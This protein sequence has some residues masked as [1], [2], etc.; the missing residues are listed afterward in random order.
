MRTLKALPFGFAVLA[1]AA[2]FWMAAGDRAAA[3]SPEK[4]V[5]A[6]DTVRLPTLRQPIARDAVITEG[7]IL[8]IDTNAR[9]LPRTALLDA[10]SIVGM[11][12]KRYLPAG[13]AILA[14]DVAEPLAVRKGD[15]VAIVY[16]TPHLTLTARGR[17]LED[18]AAGEA[19]RTLNAH[20]N[21][22]GEATAGAPG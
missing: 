14:R 6:V 3:A 10:S 22:T 11:A 16:T 19:V 7:D 21:R 5:E 1:L 8:W 18:A 9:R 13:R 2:C 4:E 12:A 20:S 15:L 17:A